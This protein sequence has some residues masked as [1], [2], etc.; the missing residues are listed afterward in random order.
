MGN[1]HPL[2]DNM[3]PIEITS[4]MLGIATENVPVLKF[5]VSDD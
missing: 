5:E 3:D 4:E 1:P 2:V